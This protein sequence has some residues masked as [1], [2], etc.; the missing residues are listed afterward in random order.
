MRR[1]YEISPKVWIHYV[2]LLIVIVVIAVLAS[3]TVV[4]Y[5]GVQ[6][7]AKN[8]AIKSAVSGW[9][10]IIKMYKA[11]KGAYPTY[12]AT[13][14]GVA[15]DYPVSDAYVANECQYISVYSMTYNSTAVDDIKNRLT[16]TIPSLP[17]GLSIAVSG[18]AAGYNNVRSR[19]I[20]YE[21]LGVSPDQG[22]L[23]YYLIGK[24]EDCTPDTPYLGSSAGDTLTACRMILD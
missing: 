23:R 13:C 8:T 20:L 5:N 10:K 19:G 22:A 24:G 11:D 12:G 4:A 16:T 9:A 17:A 14:L 21:V 15:S 18:Q 2:E 6:N 7:R 1:T 3:V